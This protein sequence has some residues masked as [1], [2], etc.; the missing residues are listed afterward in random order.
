[1]IDIKVRYQAVAFVPSIEASPNNMSQLMGLFADKGLVP[2]TYQEVAIAP[3][4]SQPQLRFSLQSPNNEWN[5]RFGIN[6]IDVLK[7]AINGK[8]DNIGSIEQ[9]CS[10]ASDI[11]TKIYSKHPQKANRLG[12]S[13][14]VLLEEMTDEKL[15]DVYNKLFNPIKLY[16]DNK[17]LEWNSRVNSRIQKEVNSVNEQINFI[18]EINRA[19]GLLNIDQKLVPI[20]RIAINLD[21]NTIPNNIENRFGE[22]EV[23]DFYKSVFA[24]H[25]ELLNEIIEK[26]K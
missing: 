1:M 7:N 3:L 24:W 16:S 13:S 18:S 10:D 11:F 4:P 9:F 20:D 21:I 5:I 22:A 8:G 15:N 14:N 23:V 6:R 26:I 19:S 2:T 25:N 12:L 17:P